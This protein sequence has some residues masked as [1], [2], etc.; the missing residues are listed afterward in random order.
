M[1]AALSGLIL[2]AVSGVAL[3]QD[4]MPPMPAPTQ[5]PA[6][7]QPAAPAFPPLA[8]VVIS[9]PPS[10]SIEMRVG[11][12][13]SIAVTRPFRTIHITNPDI[14]DVVAQTDLNAILV[15]KAAGATNVVILDEKSNLISAVNVVVTPG[16]DPG[17]VLIHNQA[18]L[19][20]STNFHCDPDGCE[21]EGEST[22]KAQ[23][24]PNGYN[25]Q[26]VTSTNT[27]TNK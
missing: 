23:P 22:V 10:Q 5:P 12:S 8:P 26:T 18:L 7:A 13:R 2:A 19:A 3:A 15:P 25:Q 1:R 21:L 14:V 16:K 4:P 24:L 9:Q 17:R 27:N 11:M 20:S 6:A